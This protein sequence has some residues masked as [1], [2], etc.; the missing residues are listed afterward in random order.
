M[1][2]SFARI[3]VAR[4]AFG[5]ALTALALFAAVPA[6]AETL[7]AIDRRVAESAVSALRA[8]RPDEAL[9]LA[10]R[11]RD[12]LLLDLLRWARLTADPQSAG[13]DGLSQFIAAHP[14]WPR[15][16]TL[17]R[18]AE[19]AMPQGMAPSAVLSWYEGRPPLTADGLARQLDALEASGRSAEATALLKR[20]WPELALN[21]GQEKLLL[22]RHGRR[23]SA[24]DH[25]AR[26]DKL[27]WDDK[28]EEA[29]RLLP[30]LDAGWQSLGTARLALND[31]KPGVEALIQRVPAS[32]KDDAG[33][34]WERLRW[35]RRAKSDAGVIELLELQPAETPRPDL[36]WQ[37]R[38]LAVRRQLELGQTDLAQ[39]LAADHRLPAGQPAA[40]AE[41]LAGFIAIT[42]QGKPD[43]A[44]V[45]FRRLY[46]MVKAPVSRARGAY[47]LGQ[48]AA[49]MGEAKTAAVWYAEAAAQPSTFYGQLAALKLNPKAPP[50]KPAEQAIPAAARQRFEAN[51]MV[52]IVRLSTTLGAPELARPFIYA[53]RDSLEDPD[54]LLQ[55]P[56]LAAD[57]EMPHVG[58]D[59]TK[60]IG[61][62]TGR[63]AASVGW[64]MMRLP[65]GIAVEPALAL[66]IIRQ[67]SGFDAQSVSPAGA[68][69][70][71]Q[72]MPTTAERTA[73]GLGLASSTPK[74]TSDA[75]HNITLG[76]AYLGDL[77]KRYN[78]SYILAIAA[79]NAGPGR[80][81]E[82]LTRFGNPGA[83]PVA[84][85]ERI[86]FNETRS[87]VQRVLENLQLYRGAVERPAQPMQLL[88]DLSR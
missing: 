64:P 63:Y 75:N 23:L 1:G 37:E 27:L 61:R 24:A 46:D 43:V 48:A 12:P 16:G 13:F 74:L 51:E 42:Y 65:N 67:E 81:D 73:R 38:N 87:Y 5:K 44:A 20:R 72:L 66:A 36:W 3:L 9:A 39:R 14:D 30:R 2:L 15:I 47:W 76:S 8:K 22:D 11:I 53:L 7:S 86:P 25:A 62:D 84:W 29:R 45:H 49:G 50:S 71:M 35:R 31:Q 80:A 82:W 83:D 52:R 59:L 17:R 54:Q 6:S 79:Y 40:E 19:R 60:T 32:L 26:I 85:I 41:F 34:L 18:Q 68:R 28:D 33:L 56:A 57:A 58:V 69:G 10:A 78:G 55:V 88:R 21:A 4:R 77:I 70:L